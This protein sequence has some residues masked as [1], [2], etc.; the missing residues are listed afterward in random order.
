MIKHNTEDS[1]TLAMSMLW[2]YQ[3]GLDENRSDGEVTALG[4]SLVIFVEHAK[5]QAVNESVEIA[6]NVSDD[7][8]D[9]P[10]REFARPKLVARRR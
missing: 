9:E 1:R 7:W 3:N 2:L 6:R 5:R 10:T 4:K 8:D